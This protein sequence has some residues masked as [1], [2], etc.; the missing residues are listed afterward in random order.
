MSGRGLH[1]LPE[2]PATGS[3]SADVA[4]LN[5][6]AYVTVIPVDDAGAL[7]PGGIEAQSE[8]V[9]ELLERELER[10]GS[11]LDLVAHLTVYLCDLE[12]TRPG[13]NRAYQSRFRAP[14]LPVRCAVGVASLARPGMLVELTAVAGVPSPTAPA[15]SAAGARS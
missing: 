9:L 5:G 13:F 14:A 12:E 1:R 8:R 7:V 10:A 4:V 11:G 2:E 3:L 15:Y 6:T